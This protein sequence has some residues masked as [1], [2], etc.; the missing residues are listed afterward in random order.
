MRVNS[1]QHQM[2]FAYLIADDRIPELLDEAD[3]FL[4]VFRLVEES[5]YCFLL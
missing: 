2:V 4:R 3:H 1:G 5:R